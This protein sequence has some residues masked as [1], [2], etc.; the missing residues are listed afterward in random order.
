LVGFTGLGQAKYSNNKFISDRDS[1]AKN[2]VGVGAR[3][4]IARRRLG[5]CAGFDIAKGLEE[6]N[7]YLI[8]G[9]AWY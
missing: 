5:M 6:T 8:V 1:D 2:T 7:F 9:S 3:Y 4:L